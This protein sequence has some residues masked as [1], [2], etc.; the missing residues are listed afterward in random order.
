MTAVVIRPPVAGDQAYVASTWTMSMHHHRK[1]AQGRFTSRKP[2]RED[3]RKVDAALDHASTRILVAVSP[4]DANHILGWLAYAWVGTMAVLLYAF[5]RLE[6][7]RQGIANQ[8][9]E[10][11]GIPGATRVVYTFEGPSTK[12]LKTTALHDVIRVEPDTLLEMKR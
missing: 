1:P 7:R 2:R 4:T 12:A 5:V 10:H 3:A 8:L 6:H 9:A 11:A